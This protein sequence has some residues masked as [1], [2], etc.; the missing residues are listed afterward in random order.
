MPPCIYG[1]LLQIVLHSQNFFIFI[2]SR[3]CKNIWSGT[4]FAKIYIW[5]SGSRRQGHNTVGRGARCCQEWALS[6]NAKYLSSQPVFVFT[7]I[8]PVTVSVRNVVPTLTSKKR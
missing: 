4:N 3:F 8:D 6:P 2:L 5:R 7:T 1:P